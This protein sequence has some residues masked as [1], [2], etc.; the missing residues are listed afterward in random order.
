ML[1]KVNEKMNSWKN[2]FAERCEGIDVHS[3]WDEILSQLRHQ[4]IHLLS[5]WTDVAKQCGEF[6]ENERKTLNS[7]PYFSEFVG[8][9]PMIAEECFTDF[10]IY[11]DLDGNAPPVIPRRSLRNFFLGKLQKGEAIHLSLHRRNNEGCRVYDVNITIVQ[12]R[13]KDLDILVKTGNVLKSKIISI[14]YT[15]EVDERWLKDENE[16]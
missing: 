10:Y 1:E 3:N 13:F 2:A 11:R 8:L 7:L 6:D 9:L 14:R 12:K 5:L 15:N 16:N 4:D